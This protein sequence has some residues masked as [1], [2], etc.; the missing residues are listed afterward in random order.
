VEQIR[1]RAL[2]GVDGFIAQTGGIGRTDPNQVTILGFWRDAGAYRSFMNDAHDRIFLGGRQRD[3]YSG[4]EALIGERVL[5]MPGKSGA[6]P[7][8]IRSAGLVRLAEC[9]VHRDRIDGFVRT[10]R[11]VWSPGMSDSPGMLGGLFTRDVD[12]DSR[13]LVATFWASAGDHDRYVSER[14]PALRERARPDLD[15]ISLSG[16]NLLLEQGWTVLGAACEA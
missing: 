9:V 11:D 5:D 10:Q 13:F 2:K 1:W 12:D 6:I 15:L 3:T 14:L 16:T 7:E 8:M 4:A